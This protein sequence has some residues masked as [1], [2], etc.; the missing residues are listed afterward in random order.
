MGMH[1]STYVGPYI[2]ADL[3]DPEEA[4]SNW[5]QEYSE[6][7]DPDLATGQFYLPSGKERA[8]VGGITLEESGVYQLPEVLREENTALQK[9]LDKFHQLDPKAS[10]HYGAIISWG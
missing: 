3:K 5:F 2:K 1:K 10:L 9:A 7:D 6:C 8:M 4:P